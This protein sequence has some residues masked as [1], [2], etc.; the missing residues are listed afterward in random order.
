MAQKYKTDKLYTFYGFEVLYTFFLESIKIHIATKSSKRIFTIINGMRIFIQKSLLGRSIFNLILMQKNSS[1][2]F[3]IVQ[4]TDATKPVEGGV[5]DSIYCSQCLCDK[6]LCNIP[7]AIA[8]RL[9]M[10]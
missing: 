9:H 5:V 6:I 2:H 7:G 3:L 8:R 10:M 1:K 4:V